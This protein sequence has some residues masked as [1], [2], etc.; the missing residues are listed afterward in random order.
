MKRHIDKSRLKELQAIHKRRQQR[1][2]L[3]ISKAARKL[4]D[5][6]DEGY[7]GERSTKGNKLTM[8]MVSGTLEAF[9][10]EFREFSSTKTNEAVKEKAQAFDSG[11]GPVCHRYR[12]KD[13][14][15]REDGKLLVALN[16]LAD[17]EK[18]LGDLM[19]QILS[20]E[21]CWSRIAH[22][23]RFLECL[24]RCAVRA[25][26]EKFLQKVTIDS[27]IFPY[28]VLRQP[29]SL[30]QHMVR[31]FWK[32][33]ERLN[34]EEIRILADM[35]PLEQ[36]MRL[37][38][39]IPMDES[40]SIPSSISDWLEERRKRLLPLKIARH[41]N[42]KD[43]NKRQTEVE[44]VWAQDPESWTKEAWAVD[45]RNPSNSGMQRWWTN[46]T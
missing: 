40:W 8:R 24:N 29:P 4:H 32:V 44:K 39:Y 22:K 9:A 25:I 43:L 27:R 34:K 1:A 5:P 41:L 20:F 2:Q 12:L 26:L 31:E 37:P 35:V 45:K 36:G 28:D 15:T 7:K 14:A 46:Q 6:G 38:R 13:S 16:S 21:G 17:N 33:S 11:I 10:Q 42:Q 3:P 23:D 18:M 30:V 19:T